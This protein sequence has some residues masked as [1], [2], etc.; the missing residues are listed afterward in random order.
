MNLE[1]KRVLREE[2]LPL[3]VEVAQVTHVGKTLIVKKFCALLR[4]ATPAPLA[5][6]SNN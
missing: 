2:E 3:L 5:D 4:P 6:Q 1:K